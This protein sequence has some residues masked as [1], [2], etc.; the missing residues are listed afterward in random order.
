MSKNLDIVIVGVGGQGTL[1][2]SRLLGALAGELGVDVKVSEVHGMSQ[3][4]GSVITYVRMGEN[5]HSPMVDQGMADYVIAFE[6]L[7]ALRA[8]PYLRD[9]GTMISN[10]GK[11]APMPVI[12]GAAQYPGGI[13]EMLQP[14]CELISVDASTIAQDAGEPR[15]VNLVL[16]G[17][18]ARQLGYDEQ[19]WLNAIGEC[20]PERF[21]STNL[22]AFEAGYNI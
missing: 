3:R 12:T 4:G 18:L 11:I 14:M 13:L 5:V 9:G 15:A 6:Q 8:V 7:E 22:K 20:V 10:T 1:L 17:V 16:M 2:A 19:L 21:R